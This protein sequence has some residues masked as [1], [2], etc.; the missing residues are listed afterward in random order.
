M[1]Q[2]TAYLRIFSFTIKWLLVAGIVGIFAGSASAFFLISLDWLTEYRGENFWLYYLLPIVGLIIGLLYHYL[3]KSVEGG[4]N[5]IIDA[6][7]HPRARIPW[8]MAPL[9]LIGTLLTHLV[10]GSAGR[11]GTAVQMSGSL[12]DQLNRIFP[13][14]EKDRKILL[15]CGVSA[16]FAS[17]FGTP[18]AGTIFAL[19]VFII[20]RMRYEA[21]IPALFAAV[22]ADMACKAL[23]ATHTLYLVPD[24][25]A[26]N[27]INLLFAIVAGLAFAFAGWLFSWSIPFF[28]QYFN[29]IQYPPVRPV[30]GGTIVLI[31]LLSIG[32]FRLAGLGIPTI[33]ESFSIQQSYSLVA[34]KMLLTALTLAAGFKGGEV[35]PLFFIGA[36][37]G[38]AL[39]VIIPLPISVL[40]AMGFVAVF[41]AAANTP[42]ACVL[43]GIELFGAQNVV[44]IAIACLVA[45]LF[46]GHTG[47]YSSQIIGSAKHPV[48]N[49]H[50]NK[51]LDQIN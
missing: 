43:M 46:S 10:G 50:K 31:L 8:R 11:E 40:A 44:F 25:A 5:Q 48:W 22:I 26:V 13:F 41:S 42:I 17:V 2:L 16:G 24:I 28:K 21:L 20:G 47:I 12:A 18:L 7:I 14:E 29:R 23:G 9:V 49:S 35:T 27:P 19:E 33:V 51:N 34:L 32:D 36:T 38:S 4:N 30:L 15:I 37:L 45:Y 3:G 39:S 6:I 1:K